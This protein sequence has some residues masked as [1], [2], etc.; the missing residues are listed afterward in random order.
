MVALAEVVVFDRDRRYANLDREA[1]NAEL[2][3]WGRWM[4]RHADFSGFPSM[5][6]LQRAIYGAGGGQAGHRILC[7]EMPVGVYTTHQRVLKLDDEQQEAVTA[8]YVVRLKPDGT[9][10][11]LAEKCL[12]LQVTEQALR[13][14]VSR[15]RRRILGLA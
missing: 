15:A 8:W 4:E 13:Q 1:L 14:R 11:T 9:L 6:N 10:W 5:D 7:L 2:N 3:A 12:R